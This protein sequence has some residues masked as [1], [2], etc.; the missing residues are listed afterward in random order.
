M[1]KIEDILNFLPHRYPFL[2]IDR[3]ENLSFFSDEKPLIKAFGY[4][5]VTCNE[6][7]F[8][9]HFPQQMVMPGVLIIEAMAQLA[10]FAALNFLVKHEKGNDHNDSYNVFFMSIDEARFRQKVVPGDTLYLDVIEKK[11]RKFQKN[12]IWYFECKALVEN[13][14]VAEATL[15]AISEPRE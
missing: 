15:G 2:L 12:G 9:G 7:F 3:V 8:T 13:K 5:N 1:F 11:R 10:C 6:N 14:I 4:K